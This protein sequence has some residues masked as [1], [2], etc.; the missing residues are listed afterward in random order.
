VIFRVEL[1]L[2]LQLGA[3][4]FKYTLGGWSARRTWLFGYKLGGVSA[5]RTTRWG[6]GISVI[7]RIEVNLALQLGAVLF[8]A[9]VFSAVVSAEWTA[10][11]RRRTRMVNTIGQLS[12]PRMDDM[13]LSIQGYLENQFGRI[14]RVIPVMACFG[15][16]CMGGQRTTVKC[17][18][19]MG[20]LIPI[21]HFTRRLWK[22]VVTDHVRRF[23]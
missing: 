8:G 18:I 2:A 19:R 3:V 9:L 17:S 10:L 20:T 13:V 14:T 5:R 12:W 23:G 21:D 16:T 22:I 7:L 4:V 6:S 15:D 11:T 1:D